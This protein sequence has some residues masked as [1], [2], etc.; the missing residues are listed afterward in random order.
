MMQSIIEWLRAEWS[1]VALPLAI[2]LLALIGLLWL[3]ARGIESLKKRMKKGW[4]AEVLLKG[5]T[6]PSVLWC[7]IISVYIGLAV[8]SLAADWKTVSMRALW[9]IFII[10]IATSLFFMAR[11]LTDLYGRK[12][13]LSMPN[14]ALFRNV[15]GIVILT[16]T[17]LG[18]LDLWGIPTSPLLLL[19]G[20]AVLALALISRDVLPNLFA[21]AQLSASKQIKVGDY[22]KL[23]TG[24]QGYV[25]EI[26]W[27]ETRIRGVDQSVIIIPNSRFSHYTV[28]N[29]G[30]P[31]KK[32]SS[33]FHF[34]SR[35]YI[36]ELTGIKASNLQEL[37]EVLKTAPESVVY[38]HTHHFLEEYHYLMSEPSNDFAVWV[39]DA[40][41]N[42]VLGERLASVDTFS[43]PNIGAL[44]ETLVGIIEERLNQDSHLREAMPGR[45]LH[46]MK[47]VSFITP[48]SYVAHDLREFVEGLRKIT[49]G[50]LFF[51]VFESRLRLGRGY[52]DFAI[53]IKD[54]LGETELA[55]E[56]ARLDPYLYTL[57]G[58]RSALIQLIEKPIK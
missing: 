36:T 43:Y 51:H 47:S 3:R 49:P 19:I 33:P 46:F 32:A 2:F 44:R 8:S 42:A 7:L 5:I 25:T 52:N 27:N 17:V 37:A 22:I 26:G 41:G 58:L 10:S 30:V 38:Y 21:G 39:S 40:L 6:G 14:I 53:W 4:F 1:L 13:K 56:I 12:L 24:E 29:F 34:Q 9:S 55:E 54:S 57:E 11:D 48:T 20:L 15:I 35:S 28:T 18:L 16:I 45:E 50:S 23:E 31:L